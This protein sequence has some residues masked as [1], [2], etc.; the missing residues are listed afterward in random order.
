MLVE[1]DD[2]VSKGCFGNEDIRGIAWVLD[3][4]GWEEFEAWKRMPASSV[5][6]VGI[7]L[8]TGWAKIGFREERWN[9]AER[10]MGGSRVFECPSHL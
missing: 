9:E 10:F 7:D 3:V 8:F 1:A 4:V 5:C 6:V 2:L